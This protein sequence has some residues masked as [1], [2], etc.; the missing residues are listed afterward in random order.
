MNFY[1]VHKSS[2]WALLVII[3][4][5]DYFCF[6][7]SFRRLILILAFAGLLSACEVDIPSPDGFGMPEFLTVKA[8]G[9][10]NIFKLSAEISSPRVNGCGFLISQAGHTGNP[11]RLDASLEKNAFSAQPRGLDFHQ[12]YVFQAFVNVG[13]QEILSREF[14]FTTGG[15]ANIVYIWDEAFRAY[16]LENFDSDGDGNLQIAE[17]EAIRTIS[18]G[19]RHVTSLEGI[20][21]MTNLTSLD[22]SHNQI[23]EIDISAN[24]KLRSINCWPMVNSMQENLL[25]VIYFS[26]YA[27]EA[28]LESLMSAGVPDETIVCVRYD[29]DPRIGTL[30][31]TPGGKGVVFWVDEMLNAELLVCVDELDGA[32]WNTAVSWC[33]SY[34][35]GSWWMPDLDTLLLLHRAF[36][37]VAKTLNTG[38]FTPLCN[39]NYCYWSS[40][41]N[42]QSDGYRLRLR[43]WDGYILD[44]LGY[45][46]SIYSNA[47]R[48]RAVKWVVLKPISG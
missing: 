48:T 44:N 45:D 42:P 15:D 26:Q 40:N 25:D 14:T 18:I 41:E 21:Y 22:C 43:L 6:A 35:D 2:N 27:N 3:G 47:N 46:E 5:I 34:G 28:L 16:L 39:E 11:A 1:Q 38:G 13:E 37:P 31:D 23:T 12:E 36:Y 24:L 7:M 32:D 10:G 20:E 8:E 4:G 29:N 9:E 17:A 30:V 33:E 19:S